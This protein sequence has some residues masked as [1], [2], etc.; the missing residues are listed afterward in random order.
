MLGIYEVVTLARV[1]FSSGIAIEGNFISLFEQHFIAEISILLYAFLSFIF[2]IQNK[3]KIILR[4]FTGSFLLFNLYICSVTLLYSLIYP[5]GTISTYVIIFVPLLTFFYFFC[6]YKE[7]EK[8]IIEVCILALFALLV[9]SYYVTYNTR[10]FESL[11]GSNEFF[12]S[13]ASYFVVYLLPFLLCIRD[14]R[15]KI[16][17][18]LIAVVVCLSSVKRGST[19]CLGVGVI[20]Y[21]LELNRYSSKRW[22]SFKSLLITT[23]ILAAVYFVALQVSE[24][25]GDYISQR[26]ESLNEDRGTHRLDIYRTTLSMIFSSNPIQLLIGHGWN[27]VVVDSPLSYSAHNDFLEVLYDTGVVGFCL[28]I[29]LWLHLWR[30]FKRLRMIKSPFTA[31]LAASLAIMLFGMMYSHILLYPFYYLM[32]CAQWGYIYMASKDADKITVKL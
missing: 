26:F 1:A 11:V 20:V 6:A 7:I 3:K 29:S 31:P 22:I 23:L 16:A 32:F 25:S 17:A 19:V 13:N 30:W 9:Y 5:F 14:M 8:W 12:V 21:L 27:R 18:I 10:V 28:F 24:T 4:G 2:V 15:I